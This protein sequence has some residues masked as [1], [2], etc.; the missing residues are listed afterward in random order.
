MEAMEATFTLKDVIYI[1]GGVITMVGFYWKL[2]MDKREMKGQIDQLA[3]DN[4]SLE[5]AFDKKCEQIEKEV[6]KNEST[7]FK[8]FSNVHTRMEKNEEKN[9]DEYDLLNKELSELKIGIAS[10]DGK[11]TTIIE[12]LKK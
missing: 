10:M 4:N 9:K 1:V 7:M 2:V 11:L 5:S 12:N 8:K 3:K 6:E